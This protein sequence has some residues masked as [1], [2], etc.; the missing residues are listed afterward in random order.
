MTGSSFFSVEKI[1]DGRS[2][3]TT[4]A[5]SRIYNERLI[6][7]LV[8]R[9]GRAGEDGFDPADPGRRADDHDDRDRAA[10]RQLPLRREPLRG[11]LGEPSVPYR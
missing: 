4:Q 8:R 10:D 1:A 5:E 7:S 6:V 11:R 2:G 3:G 9:H